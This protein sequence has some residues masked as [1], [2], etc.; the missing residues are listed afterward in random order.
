MCEAQDSPIQFT[1]VPAPKGGVSWQFLGIVSI[2]EDAQGYIWFGSLRHGLLRYDGSELVNYTLDYAN[3]NSLSSNEV[4]IVCPDSSG[5]LWIGTEGQGLDLYDPASGNFTHFRN[6]PNQP[7]SLSNDTV[8]SIIIDRNGII[9]IGTHKGLDRFDY[10][11]GEFTI[12]T[13]DPRDSTSLSNNQVEIVYEDRNREI[14]VGTGSPFLKEGGDK[15]KGG[16][17]RMNLNTGKFIR[18]VHSSTDPL[19]LIDNRVG[20]LFEDDKGVFWVG[21][22]GEGLHVMDRNK[23]TFIRHLFDPD[24]PKK[25]SRLIP[26]DNRFTSDHITSISEDVKGNIFI[27]TFYG[28]LIYYYVKGDTIS[29]WRADKTDINYPT[30]FIADK[31]WKTYT[32]SNGITWITC[33]SWQSLYKREPEKRNITKLFLGDEISALFTDSDNSVWIG[34]PKGLILQD[35]NGTTLGKF[36]HDPLNRTSLSADF[37]SCMSSGKDNKIWVGTFGGGLN[38]FDQKT[39]SVISYRHNP[40]NN[41]SLSSDSVSAVYEDKENNLWLGT[42]QGLDEMNITTGE[43]T[44]FHN[45]AHDSSGLYINCPD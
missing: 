10:K 15:D 24:H 21:S 16:L 8:K 45:D 22:A 33:N 4:N 11:S 40:A 41:K 5:K 43:F 13:Y 44:H 17:N 18:Y 25:L 36:K 39:N 3:K 23:G 28:D 12:Y 1:K 29:N 27:G 42:S 20:A 6:D 37:V 2:A 30:G 26:H 38:M 14:W 34:T 19:S 35:R 9:W 32:T 31:E 7:N